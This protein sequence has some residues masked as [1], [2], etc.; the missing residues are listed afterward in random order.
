LT[1]W[2][3]GPRH[4]NG[5]SRGGRRKCSHLFGL[6]PGC[7]GDKTTNGHCQHITISIFSN[8]AKLQTNTRKIRLLPPFACV[9]P[10][11][12]AVPKAELRS[13]PRLARRSCPSSSLPRPPSL[14]GGSRP[15]WTRCCAELQLLKPFLLR[16]RR[17]GE[18]GL[19]E[20]CRAVVGSCGTILC[21]P[22][23]GSHVVVA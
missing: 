20:G 6:G 16:Q 23:E 11:D 21:V 8:S 3:R 17:W 19:A 18:G 5:D 14:P 1:S 2:R 13:T 22:V 4:D 15:P 7:R 12:L 10:G 9:P